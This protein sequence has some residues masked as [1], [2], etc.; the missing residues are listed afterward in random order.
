MIHARERGE[1]FGLSIAEFLF[2]NKPVLAW[3]G[4]HDKNHLEMLKGS[5]TLYSNEDDLNYMLHN[6]NDFKDDWSA[7]VSEFKPEIVMKKFNEVFL[8][9]TSS[10]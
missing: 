1:S 10:I 2:F 9:D 5:G 4:G 6:L 7:R 3:N 8:N